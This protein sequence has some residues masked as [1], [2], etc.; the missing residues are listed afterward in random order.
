[1]LDVEESNCKEAALHFI[2]KIGLYMSGMCKMF[3]CNIIADNWRFQKHPVAE[4]D[5]MDASILLRHLVTRAFL[6]C[7]EFRMQYRDYFL[8]ED[9]EGLHYRPEG[10]QVLETFL[11]LLANGYI[12]PSSR[13]DIVGISPVGLVMQEADPQYYIFADQGEQGMQM[14]EAAS[15]LLSSCTFGLAP[16]AETHL[17]RHILGVKSG[18]HDWFFPTPYGFPLLVPYTSP[19]VDTFAATV[20]TDGVSV[21]KD[22]E[23]LTAA[24]QMDDIVALYE[25]HA[26]DMLFRADNVFCIGNRLAPDRVRILLCDPRTYDSDDKDVETTLRFN[27]NTKVVSLVDVLRDEPVPMDGRTAAVTVPRGAFRILDATI[28]KW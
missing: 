6:G 18:G 4:H 22:G 11:K 28:A 14:K 23:K 15:G 7:T 10:R 25:K 20:E 19:I 2:A 13:E 5:V 3:G 8:R 24:S 27:E 21:L 9:E 12:V 26:D 16:A 17:L 1:V